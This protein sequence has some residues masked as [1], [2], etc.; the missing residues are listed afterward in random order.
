MSVID[1]EIVK[2]D[3][4][5]ITIV[6]ITKEEKPS[7]HTEGNYTLAHIVDQHGREIV[8]C[9]NW[10]VDWKEGDDVEGILQEKKSTRVK[11]A[12]SENEV[13]TSL[14]LANPRWS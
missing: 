11:D 5:K 9:G 14:Y 6:E 13:F 2:E 4:V 3:R 8:A 12:L 7:K 1:S 10:V